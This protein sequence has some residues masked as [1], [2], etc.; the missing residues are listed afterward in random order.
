MLRCLVRSWIHLK[1]WVTRARLR[2]QQGF[3]PQ[4]AIAHIHS[5]TLWLY[6]PDADKLFNSL[7]KWNV[8]QQVSRWWSRC[9]EDQ[10]LRFD[11]T[12]LED[13]LPRHWAEDTSLLKAAP[14]ETCKPRLALVIKYSHRTESKVYTA[15]YRQAS[16]VFPPHLHP[17]RLKIS[18]TMRIMS[19]LYSHSSI[20]ET[21]E[22][23]CFDILASLAGPQWDFYVDVPQ[24][25]LDVRWL[26]YLIRVAFGSDHD[27]LYSDQIAITHRNNQTFTLIRPSTD[28]LRITEL[29]HLPDQVCQKPDQ[30]IS[31]Y[32][33][34]TQGP[35]SLSLL[36]TVPLAPP[37]K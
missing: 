10:Q 31:T 13:F 35:G 32:A 8:T 14:S 26:F 6:E 15:L 20:K 24:C 7:G 37:L 22:S 11:L 18:R 21:V 3:H 28:L 2:I 27:E 16:V 34:F 9:Q 17:S 30:S 23:D 25:T 1:G 19:A 5:A 36:A 4:P 29:D 12:E 33:S